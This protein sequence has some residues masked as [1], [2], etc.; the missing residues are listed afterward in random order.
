MEYQG[1]LKVSSKILDLSE[2]QIM[3]IL[4]LTPDSFYDGGKLKDDASLLRMS[5]RH[6]MHGAMILDIGGYSTRPG[7]EDISI[8][9]EKYRVL[10]P[11]ELI[12]KE[13]PQAI[14]SVDTF[15][16]DVA[17]AAIGNGAHIIND[18]SGGQLDDQ[19]FNVV[20][21]LGCPYVLM[22]MKGSPQNMTTK[23]D[24]DNL[25]GDVVDYFVSRI[26]QLRALGVNDIIMDPGFGFA[27]TP[28]QSYSLLR[29]LG[30]LKVLDVPLLVGISRKSMIYKK[31]GISS[32]EALNG[33]TVLN[34]IALLNGANLLRV[35][36]V[37]EA[38]EAIKLYKL[39]YD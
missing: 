3:G 31:L 28:E 13:F 23:T 8:E 36:D 30:F 17:K 35:H 1:T 9:E 10:E 38:S 15:R 33:T 26:N 2:P 11:I 5:E 12:A 20:A 29:Q 16:S 6:L 25:L 7:A 19:M 24:Y 14:I 37:K 21:S 18:V 34:T 22:H 4:N 27:K 39:T 32:Q